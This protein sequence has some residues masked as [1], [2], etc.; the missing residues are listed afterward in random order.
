MNPISIQDLPFFSALVKDYLIGN[1][2]VQ[3]LHSFYPNMEGLKQ[4]LLSKEKNYTQRNLLQNL[5]EYNYAGAKNLRPKESENIVLLKENGYAVTTAHQPNLFLGPLYT[6]TK[7]VSVISLAEQ[8][9]E[10]LGEK[11]IVPIFVIGSEDHDK[12]ELLHTYLFGKKYEWKSRG[13]RF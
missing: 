5:L 12:E 6:L 4:A 2:K 11:N 1:E 8:M 9:N 10:A 13:S 3:S 7:A